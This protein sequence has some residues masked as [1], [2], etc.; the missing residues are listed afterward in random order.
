MS[1]FGFEYL[2]HFSHQD[3]FLHHHTDVTGNRRE[4]CNSFVFPFKTCQFHHLRH[5]NHSHIHTV[6]DGIIVCYLGMHFSQISDVLA[7]I[8]HICLSARVKE[9][10]L[11]VG[12]IGFFS[13]QPCF[14][15]KFLYNAFHGIEIPF[16]VHP[17]GK[18]HP[19]LRQLRHRRLFGQIDI[20]QF[21]QAHIP[22]SA[23]IIGRQRGEHSV[24]GN[25]P[26]NA[27]ILAQRV[28]NHHGIAQL[29]ILWKQQLVKHLGTL[30]GIGHSLAEP[31]VFCNISCHFFHPELKG[32]FS[33]GCFSGG[34]CG[35]NIVI[36][37][38]SCHF[39]CQICQAFQILSP[40]RRKY[41]FAGSIVFQIDFPEIPQHG[42]FVN[43]CSQQTVDFLRIKGN[44]SSLPDFAVH[45]HNAAYHFS[46]SQFF[47]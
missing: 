39:F 19:L 8:E 4:F 3:I 34:Q 40:G 35:R 37:I 20:S 42:F 5:I 47:N 26:H 25:R 31:A 44:S 21:I 36:S 24:Q 28:G 46:C 22:V 38:E 15:Q 6:F 18:L 23:V 30:K 43:V 10:F 12:I 9:G 17:Q 11:G 41:L 1:A 13:G 14:V 27:E 33:G 45:I 32:Q 16:S 2:L 7:V 29:T